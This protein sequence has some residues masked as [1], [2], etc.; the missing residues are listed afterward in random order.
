MHK[1]AGY[2]CHM[3][4]AYNVIHEHVGG[5]VYNDIHVGFPLSTGGGLGWSCEVEILVL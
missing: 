2:A 3:F 5:E 4:L 1:L